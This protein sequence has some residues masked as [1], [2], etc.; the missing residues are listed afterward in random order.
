VKERLAVA[1]LLLA[2][3]VQLAV[4]V[5]SDGLT[6]DELVYIGSGYRHLTAGDYRL[7]PEQ[8]PLAKLLGAIPLAALDLRVPPSRAGDSEWSWSY[9]LVHADNDADRVVAWARLPIAALTLLLGLV[10]WAWA[11]A[12][13]GPAAGVLA[14]A[15]VAFHPSLLAHGHLLTTDLAGAFTLVVASWTFWRWSRA[16]SLPRALA[17]AAATGVSVSTRLTGWLLVPAFLVLAAVEW[18]RATL[19]ARRRLLRGLGGL[20]VAGLL[21]VPAVIWAAYGFRYAPWPGESVARP[22]AES[23]GWVGR[24]IAGLESWR[25]L[26]EAYL[27]GARFVAEHNVG[28]HHTY[29]LGEVSFTGWPHY[30]LIAFLA[31]NTPGFL[32]ALIGAAWLGL[33]RRGERAVPA[34]LAH[35]LLP[36]ALMFAA[37]SFGRIQIG[38]RYILPV[39]PYLILAVAVTA[40]RLLAS[41]RGRWVAAVVLTLHA[42]PALLVAPRGYLTYFNFAAGGP[43]GGHRVLADSNLDWGQDL[44]RLAAWMR[45]HGVERVQLAYHGSDDPDRYGIVHEDLRGMHLHSPVTPLRPFTGTVAVSPNLLWIFMRDEYSA[46]RNQTPDDRAGVFFIYRLP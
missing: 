17:V 7:N 15:L 16:P 39:Y 27:E 36:A 32:L 18:R 30:Y 5:G 24:L 1:A 19:E 21:V 25:L 11:R 12:A 38:E 10:V 8:P 46:L 45:R 23:L 2:L 41:R 3:G 29:L 26:P 42:V 31:K 34:R 6:I 35:W 33:R 44:P 37:A 40:A 4:A 14:L 9:Q 43:A 22:P 28:G 20:A 13:G